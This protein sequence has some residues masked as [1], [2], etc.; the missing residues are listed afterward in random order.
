MDKAL[1][2]AIALSDL[3]H[4]L[5]NRGVDLTDEENQKWYDATC[6]IEEVRGENAKRKVTDGKA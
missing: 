5:E 3:L 6:L 1:T 2:A 4:E